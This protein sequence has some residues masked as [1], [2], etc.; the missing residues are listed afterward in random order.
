M[1]I[2]ITGSTG[3]IGRALTA[4]LLGDGHEVVR[5]VRREPV[6]ATADGSIEAHWN[7]QTGFVPPEAL[8]DVDALVHLAG[9]GVGDH[10]WNAAYK[11]KIRDSRVHGTKALADSFAAASGKQRPSVFVSGSAIGYYGDTGGKAVD[12]SAPVGTDF[13]AGV[14]A[15]WEA[16]ADPAREAGIRTVHPRMGIVVAPA[17]GAYGRILPLAKLGLGGRMGNGRQYWSLISLADVVAG[18]RFAID[19]PGLSGPV[20]FTSPQPATNRELTATLGRLLHRPALLPVP[21]PALR[22]AIGEFAGTVLYSQ[23][24]L[25]ARL[26]DAGF[27]FKHPTPEATLSSAL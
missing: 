15:D 10:R 18:L 14:C 17:G 21:G 3:L 24:V 7:P 9:A 13:L 26:L 16:A 8:A 23:Q 5:L 6:A 19:T 22:L 1:R 27:T 11:R 25:P 4:S 20:N 2:V 12:E